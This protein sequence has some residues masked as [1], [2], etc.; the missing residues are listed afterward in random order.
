MNSFRTLTAAVLTI[1]LIASSAAAAGPGPGHKGD[2]KQTVKLWPTKYAHDDTFGYCTIKSEDG[3]EM[4]GI[5]VFGDMPDDTIL[6][7]QVA[8][9][10]GTFD[11]GTI[12]MF[13]GSGSLVLYSSLLPSSAFP[14]SEVQSIT[15]RDARNPLLTYD[16]SGA[17]VSIK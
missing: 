1:L 14:L 4:L 15:V 5:R 16:W 7:V 11:V 13:L 10:A 2:W 12:N 6:I 9:K 17:G 3:V 8:T